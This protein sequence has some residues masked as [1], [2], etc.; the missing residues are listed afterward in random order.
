MKSPTQSPSPI[1]R[2]RHHQTLQIDESA[3]LQPGQETQIWRDSHLQTLLDVQSVSDE[4][5]MLH[6]STHI[7]QGPLAKVSLSLDFEFTDWS[8]SVYVLCPGAVYNGNRFPAVPD[9]YPPLPPPRSA[10][11]PDQRPRITRV[12]RLSAEAGRSCLAIP[13]SDAAVP[14]IGLWFPEQNRGLWILT[15][16]RNSLGLFGYTLEENDARD[17]AI[18]SI[19]SPCVRMHAY[20]MT[21]DLGP[22]PDS[23][24]DLNAGDTI[25]IRIQVT[26]FPCESVQELYDALIPLR[27][28]M[29]PTPELPCEI[30]LSSVWE[31]QE[32]KFNRENWMEDGGYYAVGVEP[33]RSQGL[34]QDWQSGWVGGMIFTHA[35]WLRGNDL[36]RERVRRNFDFLTE[37]GQA[38]SGFY[39][40]V[41]NQGK[42]LGDNFRDPE[43]PWHLLRKSA[44]VLF[45]GLSTLNQMA[46]PEINSAWEQGFRRCADAFVRLWDANGQFGQFVDH[47][48]GELIVSGSLSAGIAPAGLVLAARRFP[49]RAKDYMRVAAAAA[50]HYDAEYLRQGLTNGGPGEIAQCPDSESVAGFLE[51]LVTL[52]EETGDAKWTDAARRC[53]VQASTWV[54]SYNAEFPPESTFALMKM[55]SAGTVLANVQN[56]HSAPGICTHSGLSLL[57]LYRLTKEPFFMDLLRDIARALPQYMSRED[58]PIAWKIPYNPPES[59]DIRHLKPGWMCER[60]NVTQWGPTE[61]AGEVFYYSCWSEGALALTCAELPGIYA[62]P[63]TGG[64]WCIDA[65]EAE[66]TDESRTGIRVHNPARFPAE[67]NLLFEN[68]AR[69][70][71]TVATL[72]AGETVTI[73]ISTEG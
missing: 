3:P 52:A 73:Q 62:R 35:L 56:K 59:P 24:V 32:D 40:G 14:G 71:S 10:K 39:Y 17:Q 55:L 49:D 70:K 18:L 6:L 27:N 53:A 37:K 28:A 72:G 21:N 34:Y 57:R 15:P 61:L 9:T 46:G 7:L 5:S 25:E 31:I 41:I 11:D 42:I 54:F 69:R 2:I 20:E 13:S 51:S 33:M 22:S 58:R 50:E 45:Y 38:P 48:T 43:A 36:T 19:S 26:A 64:L 4:T 67:I 63:D 8:E 44:D 47:N 1:P 68:N 65:V 60:V 66:W 16:E 23:P 12:P 30:P 29:V